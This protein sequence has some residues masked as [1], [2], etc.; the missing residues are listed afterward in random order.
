MVASRRRVGTV[1]T[2]APVEAGA[3]VARVA[4]SF[5]ERARAA[6]LADSAV[7]DLVAGLLRSP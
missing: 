7:L 5:V 3:E 4:R 1:V 2:G 6:G